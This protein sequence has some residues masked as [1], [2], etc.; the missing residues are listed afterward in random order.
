MR[1]HKKK[2]C[3]K[4]KTHEIPSFFLFFLLLLSTL[5]DGSVYFFR[6]ERKT[7][8]HVLPCLTHKDIH[9]ATIREK[10]FVWC[11]TKPQ[12]LYNTLWPG[13]YFFSSV[14]SHHPSPVPFPLSFFCSVIW[15]KGADETKEERH[16]KGLLWLIAK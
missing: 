8:V 11:Q 4:R 14:L 9:E 5:H 2:N 12:D 7:K 3:V 10:K 16:I 15:T 13:L 1:K 6:V